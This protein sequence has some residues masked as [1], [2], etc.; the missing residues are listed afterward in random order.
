MQPILKRCQYRLILLNLFQSLHRRILKTGDRDDIQLDSHLQGHQDRQLLLVPPILCRLVDIEVIFLETLAN[1]RFQLIYNFLSFPIISK[2]ATD[3][4]TNS[5]QSG[6]EPYML[7]MPVRP[8][9]ASQL[10]S[11]DSN[12]ENIV[13]TA[14]ETFNR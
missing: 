8:A 6:T 5:A 14:I 13:A 10:S 4:R 1:L 12:S 3:A 7:G 11:N 9:S 2:S